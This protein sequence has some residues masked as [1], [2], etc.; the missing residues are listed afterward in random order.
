M[1]AWYEEYLGR[2]WAPV[3]NPPE[4]FTCGELVRYVFK[5]EF[6]F[7]ALPVPV[8]DARNLRD[9]VKAMDPAYFG[10]VPAEG[11][12]REMDAAF[13]MRRHLMDHCGLVVLPGDGV[14]ILHCSQ[15][16]GVQLSSLGEL[17]A[18]G[19]FRRTYWRCPKA[20]A[21]P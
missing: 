14:W 5:R 9:C 7:D 10:L 12:L 16:G 1:A 11:R 4:S 6:G 20:E 19:Y 8:P 2:P 17:E 15:R 3:P 18:E 21:A 13:L